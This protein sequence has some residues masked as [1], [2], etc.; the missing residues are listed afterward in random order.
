MWDDVLLSDTNSIKAV[1]TADGKKYSDSVD[2]ITA[3]NRALAV[4]YK[5]HVQNIG[6]Q[7]NVK[8]GKVSGTTGEKKQ[9]EA[10]QIK[11]LQ[12]QYSGSIEYRTHVQNIGWQEW[13]KDGAT[14]GTT[15]RNLR[16]EALQIGLTGELAEH[17]DI[18]YRVHAQNYGKRSILSTLTNVRPLTW[19]V[20]MTSAVYGSYPEA[21]VTMEV[22]LPKMTCRSDPCISEAL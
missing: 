13:V 5:S 16:V 6:W 22:N 18:Y 9:I 21:S 11:L 10:L 17:Y 8:D 19:P 1:G 20:A 4:S 2:G 14:A 3:N 12:D 7:R 15:G